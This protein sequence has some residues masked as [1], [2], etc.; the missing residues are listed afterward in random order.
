PGAAGLIAV[1]NLLRREGRGGRVLALIC[2][3]ASLAWAGL[4]LG[5]VAATGNMLDPRVLWHVIAAVALALFSLK[6]MVERRLPA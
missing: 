6:S 3:V 4:A 2:L 1:L 5:F